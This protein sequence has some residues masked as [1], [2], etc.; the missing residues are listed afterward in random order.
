MFGQTTGSGGRTRT[1][2]GWTR[3]S[4]VA[5]YTTPERG[6]KITGSLLLY[7]PQFGLVYAALFV[8]AR[9]WRILAWWAVGAVG[10]YLS[11]ALVFGQ[12]WVQEWLDQV[13]SFG[14]R[15][16]EVNGDLMV[17]AIGFFE[18]LLGGTGAAI[19]ALIVIGLVLAVLVPS[20]WSSG[21][22]PAGMALAGAGLVLLAPSALYYDA[23]LV[24]VS[25]AIG[26]AHRYRHAVGFAAGAFVAS[27]S[28][29]LA[30]SLGFSPVFFLVVAAFGWVAWSVPRRRAGVEATS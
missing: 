1:P 28:Q 18:N 29:L 20:W 27:W 17:S 15:N 6:R 22:A 21:V 3:T 24:L 14:E 23:G 16:L 12:R 11:A 25:L 26:L 8:V 13:R 9:R 30:T 4:C 10:L 7:K 2:N 19:A 5:N